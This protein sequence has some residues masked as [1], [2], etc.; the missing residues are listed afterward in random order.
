MR[1]MISY[2]SRSPSAHIIKY[3]KIFILFWIGLE[4]LH[5]AHR[6]P[7]PPRVFLI[8]VGLFLF[9]RLLLLALPPS[10]LFL[11]SSS[12]IGAKQFAQLSRE[13]WPYRAIALLRPLQ[14]RLNTEELSWFSLGC[15]RTAN[16][17]EWRT[18]VFHLM[19]VTPVIVIN[20][21]P[22][23]SGL[24]E[25]WKRIRSKCYED[26]TIQFDQSNPS[27]SCRLT[28]QRLKNTNDQEERKRRQAEFTEMLHWLPISL[29]YDRSLLNLIYR[30]RAIGQNQYEKYL[31]V[32]KGVSPGQI[33]GKLLEDIPS[34]V[35]PE[36]E[37]KFLLQSR[38]YEEI[39]IL[40]TGALED[41]KR[42]TGKN[43]DYNTANCLNNLGKLARQQHRWGDAYLYLQ[44][45]IAILER[46]PED[47]GELATSYYLLGETRMANY[48]L[49]S[50]GTH[51]DQAIK[52]LNQ[53]IKIDRSIGRNSVDTEILITAIEQ[54]PA[55]AAQHNSSLAAV[56]SPPEPKKWQAPGVVRLLSLAVA[57]IAFSVIALSVGKLLNLPNG[58]LS[59]DGWSRLPWKQ[60]A[61][62][63]VAVLIG[64]VYSFLMAVAILSPRGRDR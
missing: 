63:D 21:D 22:E 5:F 46:C 45:A 43:V 37:N 6:V 40:L 20:D 61:L 26:R 18:I 29:R 25:E 10:V 56:S 30:Y 49:T 50:D 14:S 62:V 35:T 32:C 31:R 34:R 57:V 36:E 3:V 7:V 12:D 38:A 19:D 39:G 51:K 60:K 33:R 53:A 47:A 15:L 13:L 2:T 17:Y 52:H 59:F 27:S 16:D 11:S 44:E 48:R 23:A 8:G 54:T 9:Q 42:Y 64:S 55:A 4:L 24:Q 1:Q 58:W 28:L 41:V